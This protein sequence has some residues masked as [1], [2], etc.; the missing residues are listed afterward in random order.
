MSVEVARLVTVLEA[1]TKDFD[2][3]MDKSHS[4]L[5]KAG[6]AAGVAGLAIGGALVT[7][8]TLSVKAAMNAQDSQARL[9]RAFKN[10]RLS[11]G[12]YTERLDDVLKSSR[13][14]GF[15]NNEVRDSLGTLITA[16]GSYKEA[17]EVMGVAQDL[18]RFKG[19][20]LDMATK[21]LT[22]AM[23]GS[24]RAAKQLGITVPKVTDAM[25]ALKA[26]YA[27]TKGKATELE[28]AHAKMT[29]LMSTKNEVIDAVSDKVKGQGKAYADTATGAM[30]V[31][32][33]K[34]DNI[35]E[36]AG[37]QLLPALEF[38]VDKLN[39]F[40]EWME[41]NP[42][43]VKI[44]AALIGV[45]AGA[46]MLAAGAAIALNLALLANPIGAVA[47]GVA[48]LIAI[49]VT[50]YL[51]FEIVRK[52][53]DFL[54]QH[55][56]LL[57][58]SFGLL[59]G[60]VATIIKHW[61]WLKEKAQAVFPK[62]M[63]VL[64][65]L[66]VA[67]NAIKN[68]VKWLIDHL[69]DIKFPSIP[70]WVPGVGGGGGGGQSSSNKGLIPM[71]TNAVGAAREMGWKGQVTSGFRT[72]QEQAA[73]YQR[74]LAGGPLAARPGTSS[75]EKGQ[76]VDVTDYGTFGRMMARLPE[77]LGL[78]NKLGARDP[79]HFSVTGYDK[80]GWLPPGLSLAYNGLG[81]PERVG[82]GGNFV[83]NFPN[84]VGSKSELMSF[85]QNAAKKWRQQN[86]RSAF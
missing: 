44:M 56:E 41:K 39:E 47:L 52:A 45:L 24:T 27:G 8:M 28:V 36:K 65:P 4:R 2:R 82:G 3:A 64:H 20:G 16:T 80:G 26:K 74:Y 13:E 62:I 83:F 37:E 70:D 54:K 32:N 61:D 23:A 9:D 50:L 10:A 71:V 85:M 33:A 18:A 22:G 72:Y 51:K 75:H 42:G 6:K 84:Y 11:A 48:A 12:K 21:L 55:W 34:M 25:D 17:V 53:V 78:K 49:L 67:F 57:L 5:G 63:L 46:L 30:E 15:K 79:V 43:K 81:V 86:G 60:I 31:F 59:P 14:L 19:V 58:F 40:A 1:Q 69:D 76:A 77:G 7:G 35:K 73:L 29:D 38:V 66:V 68:A